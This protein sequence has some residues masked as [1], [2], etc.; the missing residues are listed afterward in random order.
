MPDGGRGKSEY[1]LQRAGQGDLTLEEMD[2]DIHGKHD[3]QQRASWMIEPEAMEEGKQDTRHVQDTKE[4]AV[5]NHKLKRSER[6][7]EFFPLFLFHSSVFS[8]LPFF[9]LP[10]FKIFCFLARECRVSCQV[11]QPSRISMFCRP[12]LLLN[13]HTDCIFKHRIRVGGL[14]VPEFQFAFL[15]NSDMCCFLADDR[16]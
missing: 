4:M 2:A 12:T 1:R 5:M 8:I 11:L 14:V 15:L 9:P 6:A 10:N 13:I 16:Y 7:S 3:E